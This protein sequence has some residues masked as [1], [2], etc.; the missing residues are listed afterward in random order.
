MNR[1][2]REIAVAAAYAALLILLAIGAP[3]FYRS[4]QL[5]AV[6]VTSAPVIVAAVGM[7]LVILTRQIDISIGSQFSGC[8]LLAGILAKTGLP[9][10]LV[11]I[12]TI[13]AG[14]FCGAANGGLVAGLGLPSIVVTL[15]TMV[16]LREGLRWWR[17]GEFVRDLPSSF[18]WFGL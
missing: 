14:G 6:L 16:I 9:M 3:R 7:T 15:A 5:R 2:Q 8:G 10:P 4:D 18:Q 11:A 1:Y 12:C 13:A 17:E